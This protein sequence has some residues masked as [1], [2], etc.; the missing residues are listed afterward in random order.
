MTYRV[1]E[2]SKKLKLIVDNGDIQLFE[3]I[4][5]VFKPLAI[6][7]ENLRLVRR[8]RF[9]YEYLHPGQYKVYYL[10]IRKE[11]VGYCV[12]AP[13]GRRL[14]VSEKDDVVFGPYFILPEYRGKGYAKILVRLTLEHCSYPYKAAYDWIHY[15]NPASI[16]TSEACGFRFEGSRL[17]IVGLTRKIQPK[18]DGGYAIYVYKK[19]T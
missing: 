18:E 5:S 7:F 14:W 10:A 17:D 13:G 1:T 12:V 8:C 4:P 9:L 15:S 11:L 19:T 6:P 2:Y 3:Y 16:R